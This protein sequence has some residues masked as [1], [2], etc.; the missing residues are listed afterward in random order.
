MTALPPGAH[1]AFEMAAAELGLC[2]ASRLFARE[3]ASV[4]GDSLIAEARDRLGRDY[5]VFDFIAERW[6]AGERDPP[7]NPISVVRTL[8]GITRLLITSLE[9]DFMD[10]LVPALNDVEIGLIT[11]E[12]SFDTNWRRV[13]ANY[14]GRVKQVDLA[15]L[16]R[17]AGRRSAL[18]GFVYG[19]N[20]DAAYVNALWLRISGPDVRTQFRALV[21]W[22]ILGRPML[23]YP[24]WLVETSRNDFSHIVGP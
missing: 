20:G 13:L 23:V 18:L 12:G 1:Q 2:S 16:Q 4:S 17:W 15:S 6:L 8:D 24:R 22:D 10:A 7:I 3:L 14:G 19:T 5:P 21:G 11:E 9:A